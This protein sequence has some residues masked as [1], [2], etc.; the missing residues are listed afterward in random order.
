MA[1][2]PKDERENPPTLIS[3]YTTMGVLKRTSGSLYD[4]ALDTIRKFD[5]FKHRLYDYIGK[6]AIV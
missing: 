4:V 5:V 3:A 1:P 2:L 6:Q